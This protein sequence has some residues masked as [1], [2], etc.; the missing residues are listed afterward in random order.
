MMKAKMSLFV[1]G[2]LAMVQFTSAQG[3]VEECKTSLSIFSEHYKVKN[4]KAAYEPWKKVYT[5]CPDLHVA[6]YSYGPKIIEDKI[7]NSTGAEQEAYKKELMKVFDDRMKYFASKTKEGDVLSK[8]ADAMLKHKMGTPQETMS[9]Y[10]QAFTKDKKNFKNP[11]SL[12]N[13]FDLVYKEHEAGKISLEDL[14]TKYEELSEKFEQESKG[15]AGQLKTILQKEEAGTALTSKEKRTKKRAETNVKAIG[16][17]SGNLDALIAGKAT[18]ENL[19]PLYQKN[20]DAK[21]GDAVWLKRAAGRMNKKECTEDPMFFKLVE[22]LNVVEP[23]AKS[24]FYLGRLA[25]KQKKYADAEKY[26]E[27]SVG[28]HTDSYDKSSV[29]LV[30]AN[31]AKKRGQKGKSRGMANKALAENP[32]NGKAYLL[33]ATLYG[34][35]ANQCGT[36]TFEKKAVYWLAADTARKAGRVDASLRSRANKLAKSYEARVPS[37]SEIFNGGMAG[38]SLPIGCWI[39]R[40]IKVPSL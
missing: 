40:T 24:A 38:K 25:E 31:L 15:L 4:Y 20:F 19:V 33:I 28:M 29:Y 35:S 27:Q 6:T 13:Y 1:I 9:V 11:R 3:N 26:Y 17:F 21:K 10:S 14:F 30:M 16:V 34:S 32:S 37:K 23:S 5:E 7:K 39:G 8:K 18:C 36:T 12:Y 22:A 2:L